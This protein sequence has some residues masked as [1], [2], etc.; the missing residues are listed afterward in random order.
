MAAEAVM[1]SPPAQAPTA[2][3]ARVRRVV[4]GYV[5]LQAACQ[6]VLIVPAIAPLRLWVRVAAFGVNLALL[7]WVAGRR[8]SH[9]A[10]RPGLLVLAAV[11]LGMLHPDTYL[12]AGMAQVVLYA[13]ILA[14]LYWVPRLDLDMRVLR[15]TVFILWAF[16]SASAAL[17]ILQVAMPGRFQPP[18]SSII[19]S[20]GRSYMETLKITTSTGERV[21]RPMGLSDVPG[22]AGASGLYTVLFG[23]GFYITARRARQILASLGSMGIGMACLYLAQIRSLLVMTAIAVAA[24]GAVLVWRREG[25]KVAGILVT[26][27][28]ASL[29]GYQG[30]SSLAGKDVERRVSSLTQAS[31]GSVYYRNRGLFLQETYTELLPRYPLGAGLGRW[32]MMA[33]YFGSG[34]MKAL[35]VEIQWAAW[36]VDGG[37]PLLLSYLLAVGVALRTTWRLVRASRGDERFWAAIVFGYS[38][39]AMGLTFSY[40]IF[41]S[42]MG[43]EFWLLNAALFAALRRSSRARR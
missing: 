41:V 28:L 32:G 6:V 21:Y 31:P 40:P 22:G 4:Q 43:A 3:R 18:V 11:M 2:S 34:G 35:W 30:A 24:V 20:K 7:A 42:Q 36:V 16:H 10:A 14:P 37:W 27:A 33:T 19:Q 29:L 26:V 13:A 38:A 39:G 23:M 8:S 25:R 5:L 15:Q 17:G 9:P 1:A 12:L